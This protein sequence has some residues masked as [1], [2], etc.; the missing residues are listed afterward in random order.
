MMRS[1]RRHAHA[2]AVLDLGRDAAVFA[3]AHPHPVA[4]AGDVAAFAL[5]RSAFEIARPRSDA[6]AVDRRAARLDGAALVPPQ[7]LRLDGRIVERALRALLP[8]LV[9]RLPRPARLAVAEF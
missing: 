1:R 7:H 5:L 4:A 6:H 2:F 3:P 9:P 8:A